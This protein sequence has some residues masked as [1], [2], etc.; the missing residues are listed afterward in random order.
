MYVASTVSATCRQAGQAGRQIERSTL[1]ATSSAPAPKAQS[2]RLSSDVS[3]LQARSVMLMLLPA[4]A[5]AE[6]SQD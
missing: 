3:S 1:M 4:A 2:E 5:S 6:P